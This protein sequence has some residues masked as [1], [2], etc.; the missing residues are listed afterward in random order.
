[1]SAFEGITIGA[2]ARRK[3][4]LVEGERKGR[5]VN[6]L[7]EGEPGSMER[8]VESDARSRLLL[9]DRDSAFGLFKV[10][11]SVGCKCSKLALSLPAFEAANSNEGVSSVAFIFNS[12]GLLGVSYLSFLSLELL[13]VDLQAGCMYLLIP[14]KSNG[15]VA[16]NSCTEGRG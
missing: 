16:G 5:L 14:V 1:M 7:S 9:G 15:S 6:F 8:S 12:L 3:A 10:P 13:E 11:P 4:F 2:D